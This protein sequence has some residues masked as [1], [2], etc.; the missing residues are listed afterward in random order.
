MKIYIKTHNLILVV[1]LLVSSLLISCSNFIDDPEIQDDPNRATVVSADLL[2]NAIQ[3]RQFSRYEGHTSRTAAI[4]TQQ[5]AG[6][7]RQAISL[8]KYDFTE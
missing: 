6:V 5:L 7:D 4:W 8:G 1:A 2:F 3:V